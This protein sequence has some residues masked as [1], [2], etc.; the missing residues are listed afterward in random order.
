M[1]QTLWESKKQKG[2][3]TKRRLLWRGASGKGW[4][5][6]LHWDFLTVNPAMKKGAARLDAPLVDL[7][8]RKVRITAAAF[9]VSS[10]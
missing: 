1:S 5:A 7:V 3:P 6:P 2:A 8:I 10:Q 9:P 4:R